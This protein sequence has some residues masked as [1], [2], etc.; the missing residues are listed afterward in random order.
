MRFKEHDILSILL[1]DKQIVLVIAKKY[2]LLGTNKM[3]QKHTC[4]IKITGYRA[5][6]S[7]SKMIWLVDIKHVF[8]LETRARRILEGV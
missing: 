8:A 1:F 4:N 6:I 2:T 3:A 7:W 5:S